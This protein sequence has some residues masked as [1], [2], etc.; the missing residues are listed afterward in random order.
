LKSQLK[1]KATVNPAKPVRV[2]YNQII[3]GNENFSFGIIKARKV[4]TDR[5]FKIQIAFVRSVIFIILFNK[6]IP[7]KHL[8]KLTFINK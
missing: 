4:I 1:K 3:I 6:S 2:A 5:T 7:E 8:A